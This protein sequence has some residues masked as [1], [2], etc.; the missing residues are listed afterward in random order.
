MEK[1]DVSRTY[2]PRE[3]AENGW[4]LSLRGT[5]TDKGRVI[6]LINQGKL[7]AVDMGNGKT[8]YWRVSGLEIVRYKQ[9]VEGTQAVFK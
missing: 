3:I 7:K 8:K 4:I 6:D 9:H 5:K 1:I 2:S